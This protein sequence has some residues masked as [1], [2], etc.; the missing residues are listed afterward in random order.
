MNESMRELYQDVIMDHSRKPRNFRI[1]ENSNCSAEGMNPL[2]GD[3]ISVHLNLHDH[4]IEDVGFQG[5]GCAICTASASLMTETVK[6]LSS[7]QVQVIFDRFHDLVTGHSDPLDAS[8]QVGKLAVFAGVSEFP[9]RVKCATLAWHTLR[10]ALAGEK[11][12]VSTE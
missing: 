12:T 6:G 11:D 2:C 7:E 4:N 9:I 8:D 3:H 10:A 5:A 1:P